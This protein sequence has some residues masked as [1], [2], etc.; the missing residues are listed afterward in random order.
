[1]SFKIIMIACKTEFFWSQTGLV[2]R[3]TV[4]DH[5]V[6]LRPHGVKECRSLW[7]YVASPPSKVKGKVN[8]AQQEIVKVKGGKGSGFI[9]IFI[10]QNTW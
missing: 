6:G 10:H 2:L 1:M 7:L 4:S 9:I 3:P 8:H 5:M